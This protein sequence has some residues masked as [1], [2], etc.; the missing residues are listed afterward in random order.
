MITI[1]TTIIVGIIPKIVGV[2]LMVVEITSMVVDV[3][4]IP[5]HQSAHVALYDRR[6]GLLLTG[7]SLYP[8]RLYISNFD[9]YLESNARLVQFIQDRPVQW[10]LGTH[11]EMT[12]TDGEDFPFG[13]T[14]HP[15]EHPLQL[16][17][18][19]L[20]ELYQ[21]LLDMQADPQIEVHDSF[22]IWPL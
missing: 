4:P 22:I 18:D 8:G 5:G 10:V 12:N 1:I 14:H 11:I 2:I 13:A 9:Q 16:R 3:I 6:T 21:G 7:D 20:L 19:H 15:D 17:R